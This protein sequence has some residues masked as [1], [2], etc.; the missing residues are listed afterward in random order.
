[1]CFFN[2]VRCAMRF[3]NY[4]R[5]CRNDDF[6]HNLSL[7]LVILI[8]VCSCQQREFV[9]IMAVTT[10]NVDYDTTRTTAHGTIVDLGTGIIDYGHC[11]GEKEDPDINGK[12]SS[13]GTIN[14]TGHFTSDIDSI[15]FRL[16]YIRSYVR[17][18]NEIVYGE[19]KYFG[20]TADYFLFFRPL[21][22]NVWTMGEIEE[23]RFRNLQREDFTLNLYLGDEF[24]MQ[25][26]GEKEHSRL[27]E[28]TVPLDLIQSDT[29]KVVVEGKTTGFVA[30]SNRFSIMPRQPQGIKMVFVEGGT[31]SMGSNTG[32]ADQK[33]IHQV[34]VNNFE[35]NTYEISNKQYVNFLNIY[36]SESVKEGQFSGNTMIDINGAYGNEKCRIYKEA[37]VYKVD[38]GYD[39]YPVIYVSWFGAFEFC[40]YYGGRLP[41]E[42]EWEFA[43]RGGL[44]SQG[45][46]Y[47]G[48]DSPEAV[49]Y[50]EGNSIGHVHES[51]ERKPNELGLYDM[52]GNVWEWCSDWYA[53]N[54]YTM[55]PIEDPPGPE[56]G[57]YKVRRGG[58]WDYSKV[59]M[60]TNQRG[61]SFPDETFSVVGFRLVRTRL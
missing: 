31:F 60:E 49:G 51:A 53:E 10:D 29:Y 55:S 12:H 11:W 50:H 35:I 59:S 15:D 20:D 6:C 57:I 7:I 52:S 36:Q 14:Q 40:R 32:K 48:S 38:K 5:T 13:N 58:C 42:A 16:Y 18:E 26:L 39:N 24:I 27:Y 28:W 25:I 3:V 43:A 1:M 2:L 54:Y 41:T 46:I 37:G 4:N 22:Y 21:N 56:G 34:K 33:P 61:S 45:Y 23:V 47:S 19:N 30:E 8:V 44:L 17:N 9:E